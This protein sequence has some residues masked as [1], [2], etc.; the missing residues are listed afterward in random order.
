MT[1]DQFIT[2]ERLGMYQDLQTIIID[3]THEMRT[4]PKLY[5]EH[6][7]DEPSIDIRLCIDAHNDSFTWCFR[8]GDSSY[9]QR[10]TTYCAAS[11]IQLDTGT[12]ELLNQLIGDIE[13]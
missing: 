2:E 6:G 8:T 11:S 10:H 12:D 1:L 3:L 4:D 5:T 7:C 9:D 13:S